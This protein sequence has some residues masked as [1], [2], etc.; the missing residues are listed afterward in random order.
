LE[1]TF[2]FGLSGPTQFYMALYLLTLVLHVFL[3]TYVL[4]G[5][6]MMAWAVL[7]PGKGEA[8]RTSQPLIAMLRDWS[9]FMLSGAITAAVAPLL[10]AQVLFAKYFYTAN[11][12]LGWRWMVVVPVLILAFYL[13]YLIKSKAT[14]NWPTAARIALAVSAAGCF[15]FVAFCW[16]ANHLLSIAPESWPAVYMS[17]KLIGSYFGV[18][19]RLA[20][21][22]SGAFPTMCVLAAWQLAYRKPV[23]V[24]EDDALG[25]EPRRMANI[26]LVGLAAAIPLGLLYLFFA[27]ASSRGAVF[28]PAG[29][30]WIAGLLLGIGMQAVGW[31]LLRKRE[32]F[33]LVPIV[34][35]TLGSILTLASTA[36]LREVIRL[37]QVDLALVAAETASAAKVSGFVVFLIFALLNLGLIGLCIWLVKTGWTDDPA[38]KAISSSNQASESA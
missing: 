17:G 10:F 31:W 3:M 7:F 12:L 35:I 34:T 30:L 24:A 18:A 19:A 16:T 15:L 29:R 25:R 13:L 26:S 33:R 6:A 38:E 2:P 28:G 5:S 32:E 9:P 22:V 36:S 14:A 23:D 21:W 37:T 4:A 27:G 20:T 8:P 11:L 1:T